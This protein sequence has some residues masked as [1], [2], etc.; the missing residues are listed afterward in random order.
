MQRRRRQAK[1]IRLSW[2]F[3]PFS[4]PPAALRL[5]GGATVRT[6]PLRRFGR[7]RPSARGSLARAESPRSRPFVLAV[8]RLALWAVMEAMARLESPRNR[9]HHPPLEASPAEH[10]RHSP[11]AFCIRLAFRSRSRGSSPPGRRGGRFIVARR[12]TPLMGFRP[13]QLCSSRTVPSASPRRKPTCRWHRSSSA[14]INFR[15]GTGRQTKPDSLADLDSTRPMRMCPLLAFWALT[16]P[17]QPFAA[18]RI[19]ANSAALG[20]ATFGSSGHEMGAAW[21]ARPRERSSAVACSVSGGSP[22]LSFGPSRWPVLP[23]PRWSAANQAGHTPP[24]LQRFLATNAWL[25]RWRRFAFRRRA[26]QATRMRFFTC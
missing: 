23:E 17:C 24:A 7:P 1:A 26:G 5:S 8:F 3:V 20:F 4:E 2:G 21:R 11:E 13:S 15:R 25:F 9:V 19:G 10:L 22:L 12:P 14:P 18:G 6:V 16:R